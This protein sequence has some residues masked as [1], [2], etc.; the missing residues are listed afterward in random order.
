MQELTSGEI[1]DDRFLLTSPLAR[2]G[3]AT[4]FKAKDLRDGA[5]VVV[6]VPLPV[7][8]GGTG[9]WSM[10]Q[11]EE[12]I[13]LSLDHPFVLRFVPP[14][15][16][17][18][19]S[20]VVTE[21]VPGETLAA[22]L[23]SRGPLPEAEAVD[24]AM[25]LCDAVAHMHERGYVHYDVKPANVMIC[26]DGGIRLL[27]LGLAHQASGLTLLGPSVP[28]IASSGY[29]APEQARRKRGRKS[30]DI[31]ATGAVLYEMLTGRTPFPSDEVLGAGSSLLV[32]DPPAP[33]S[34]TPVLSAEIEEIVLRALRRSPS[35][36]YSTASAMRADLANP[37]AVAVTGLCQRLRP[38]TRWRRTLRRARYVAMVCA[39][40][41][42]VQ[43]LL[44]FLLRS[45]FAHAR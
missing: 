43:L 23:A 18:R 11:R 39:L 42:A 45:H 30:V 22:R 20:Y 3:M 37:R 26:P 19:R 4:L 10:F 35:E 5:E 7:F 9:S 41:V 1:L 24:I 40:P 14:P 29:L 17:R 2:G 31:Y 16:G 6:K 32:G 28:P 25:K 44:F 33:R 8:A 21:L 38:P 34:L 36:R 12:A 27:D 13:G 15:T